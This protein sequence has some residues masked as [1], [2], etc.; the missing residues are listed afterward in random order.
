MDRSGTGDRYTC[1]FAIV[2]NFRSLI[3]SSHKFDGHWGYP[4]LKATKLG[5]TNYVK[6]VLLTH[7]R[8]KLFAK[9]SGVKWP[10]IWMRARDFDC[11]E[12]YSGQWTLIAIVIDCAGKRHKLFQWLGNAQCSKVLGITTNTLSDWIVCWPVLLPIALWHLFEPFTW[13]VHFIRAKMCP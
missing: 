1:L 8:V 9:G 13:L 11:F 7:A 5:L 6:F 12:N 3:L 4:V 10:S 2:L